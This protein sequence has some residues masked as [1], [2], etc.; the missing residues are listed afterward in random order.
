MFSK[1]EK[2]ILIYKY[3]AEFVFKSGR[4]VDHVRSQPRSRRDANPQKK[5]LNKNSKNHRELGANEK[6][7]VVGGEESQIES[8]PWQVLLKC[9]SV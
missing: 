3:Q 6:F 1:F 7:R 8:F 4:V 5:F 2:V 9:L